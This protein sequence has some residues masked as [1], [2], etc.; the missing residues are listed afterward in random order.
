MGGQCNAILGKET[1]QALQLAACT[2]TGGMSLM[3]SMA[4]ILLGIALNDW[5]LGV[6]GQW[7][8]VDIDNSLYYIIEYAA[9]TDGFNINP[10]LNDAWFN[11]ATNGQGLLLAV[12]ADIGQMFVAWFTYDTVRP[13]EDV[14]AFL[15]EPGHR[16]LTAQGPYVGGHRDSDNFRH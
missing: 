8:D 1:V 15:G 14:T 6:A 9:S 10:G 3:I 16:W 5:P 13:P 11:L 7:N 12:Y 2:I 4:R